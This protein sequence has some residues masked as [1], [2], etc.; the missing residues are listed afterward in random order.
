M[1]HQS[2]QPWVIA[3]AASLTFGFIRGLHTSFGVF[4]AALLDTFH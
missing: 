2:N 4:F 1:A 3:G